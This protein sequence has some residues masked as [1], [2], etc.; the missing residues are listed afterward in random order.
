MNWTGTPQAGHTSFHVTKPG[1]IGADPGDNFYCFDLRNPKA[2]VFFTDHDC[3]DI[4][5]FE[6]LASSP[7]KFVVYVQKMVRDSEK[8]ASTI[9][10]EPTAKHILAVVKGD[11]KARVEKI[12]QLSSPE[13]VA[14]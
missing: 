8:Q 5:D 14:Q 12:A 1:A 9:L 11:S 4:A 2:P 7:Q 10:P 3:D 13:L 6:K